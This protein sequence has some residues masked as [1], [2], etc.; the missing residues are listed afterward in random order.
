MG[1]ALV[2]FIHADVVIGCKTKPKKI[3]KVDKY[4]M[5]S[6][7]II[8]YMVGDVIWERHTQGVL[9]YSTMSTILLHNNVAKSCSWIKGM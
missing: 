4:N 2:T 9:F 5:L 8:L 7:D 3:F 6:T 1:L